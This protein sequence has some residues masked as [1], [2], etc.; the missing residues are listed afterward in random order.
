M[1][2]SRRPARSVTLTRGCG[3]GA[4]GARLAADALV[5]PGGARVDLGTGT[6]TTTL[7]R[8][9]TVHSTPTCMGTCPTRRVVR[10]KF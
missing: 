8:P 7:G 4:G 1:S 6:G 5:A 3:R 9:T 10:A 2:R